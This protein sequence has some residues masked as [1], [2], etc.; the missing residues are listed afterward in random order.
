MTHHLLH[1]SFFSDLFPF[2]IFPSIYCPFGPRFNT[3][4]RFPMPHAV[5]LTWA[6]TASFFF[7]SEILPVTAS[8]SRL[9]FRPLNLTRWFL[10][11]DRSPFFE[12]VSRIDKAFLFLCA[13]APETSCSI[14]PAIYSR[15]VLFS[16]FLT[17]TG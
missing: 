7:P 14:S 9:F 8:F 12:A 5:R 2:P 3:R 1:V 17:P 11:R 6:E 10:L 4:N 15:T 16:S 13:S